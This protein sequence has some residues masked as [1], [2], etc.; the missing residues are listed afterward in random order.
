MYNINKI[1]NNR[2]TYKI[3]ME[4][5][6]IDS[7]TELKEAV[8]MM[9]ENNEIK[10]IKSKGWTSFLPRVYCEYKKVSE[11]K[12]YTELKDEIVK[13]NAGLNL[14][15]YLNNPEVYEEYRKEIIK[16][17]DFLWNKKECIINEV[18]VKERSFQIWGDE[19]FLESKEGKSIC[20]FNK[21]DNEKLNY[22][23]APEPFFC[24][25]LKKSKKSTALIIENKDTWYSIGKAL[26]K[27]DSKLFYNTEINLL[28]YGEG[29]KVTRKNAV[30]EFLNAITDSIHKVYYAGDIDI[31][32]VNMLYG[33][34]NCNEIKIEPFMPL[35]RSMISVADVNKMNRT[36]DNRDTSY[37]MKF[38]EEFNDEEKIVIKEI[39]DNNKRIPQ[40]ILNY[41][42]YIN[43]AR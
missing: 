9:I 37:N 22:Y 15:R 42:D 27:S 2:F 25:E 3:I 32:G 29:N 34:I 10:P 26:N 16:L 33:S 12:D 24:T 8:D 18:S 1:K 13:L 7:Y 4:S 6:N 28:I 40:E 20:S 30:T 17:S 41:Q 21:L 38:L 39:L 23:Y 36:E 31:A 14:S 5:F 43:V 19:K 35:Y 11:K